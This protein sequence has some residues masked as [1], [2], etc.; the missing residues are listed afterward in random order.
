MYTISIA[1]IV[2]Q[3]FLVLIRKILRRDKDVKISYYIFWDGRLPELEIVYTEYFSI[4]TLNQ[5]TGKLKIL[6]S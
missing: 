1:K 4:E 2:S 3:F 5:K 6:S